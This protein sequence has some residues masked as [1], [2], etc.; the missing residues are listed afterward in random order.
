MRSL[1]PSP[2]VIH[3]LSP[4]PNNIILRQQQNP[5]RNNNPQLRIPSSPQSRT[6]LYSPRRLGI[7]IPLPLLPQQL[8]SQSTTSNNRLSLPLF[9]TNINYSSI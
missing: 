1:S 6:T 5:Q 2:R 8:F 4:S 7:Q 3:S 9:S